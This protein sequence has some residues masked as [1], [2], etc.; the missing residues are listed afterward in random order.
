[1]QAAIRLV[2]T[3][4]L[5]LV[6]CVSGLVLAQ[7]GRLEPGDPQLESGEYFDVHFYEGRAGE[8]L[9][10]SIASADFDPFL[11]LLAPDGSELLQVDDSPGAGLGVNV[12]V[13]L[14]ADGSY[15]VA[16]T[17]AFAGETGA[18]VLSMVGTGAPAAPGPMTKVPGRGGANQPPAPNPP[19][20]QPGGAPPAP[21][22][23]P[24]P[25]GTVLAPGPR[26]SPIP[27]QPGLTPRIGPSAGRIT[28][29][30]FDTQGQPMAGV[31]VLVRGVTYE[32][33]ENVSFETVTGADGTY[34]IRVP[35]GRYGAKAW[36]DLDYHGEFFSR[37]LHP[38]FLTEV[39]T[40]VGGTLDF[41]WVLT[42]LT[43]GRPSD[44]AGDYYGASIDL[45]YCGLPADAYCSFDYGAFPDYP[46]APGGST[47][48]IT[49]VPV[50]PLLDGTQGQPIV[51]EFT[52]KD[53]D[54]EYPHGGAPNAP[55]GFE[56]GGGGRLTL[57]ADWQYRSEDL[58]DIPVGVYDMSAVAFLPD[59]RSQALKLGLDD[60]DVEHT[61]LRISFTPW[62]HYSGRSYSG[63]GLT[64]LDVYI[65]D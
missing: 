59:G 2:F 46:V 51:F 38:L 58:F 29:T 34:S 1:M 40:E 7:N 14:P 65:R 22:A 57:G 15:T 3:L 42:G 64:Q 37:L 17:S 12:T 50:A 53:V 18:Y 6:L 49:L 13:A 33:G 23:P 52:A 31:N 25:A 54:P 30:A 39:D 5:T 24:A 60:D 41:Q 56:T 19:A 26:L 9:T 10:I 61:T 28:G 44:V 43:A 11:V 35:E 21:V 20:P 55:A 36:V 16:V 47:V 32:K 45:G 63:G 48:R 4:S 62:D 27:V 8:N